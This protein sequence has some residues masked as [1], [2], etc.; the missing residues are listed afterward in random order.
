M[1]KLAILIITKNEAENI[2]RCIHSV[3][4]IADEILI[5]DA[6]SKDKTVQ[7]AR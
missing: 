4:A 3:A 6:F 2:A 5:I 1:A 7:I